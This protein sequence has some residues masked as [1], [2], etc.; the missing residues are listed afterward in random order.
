[1]CILAI[2]FCQFVQPRLRGPAPVV[3][4]PWG[5]VQLQNTTVQWNARPNEKPQPAFVAAPSPSDL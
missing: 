5:S 3:A 1:M 2:A 4:Q